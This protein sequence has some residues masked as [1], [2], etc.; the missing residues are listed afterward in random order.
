M[1]KI[2]TR[3][4]IGSVLLVSGIIL[5]QFGG[6]KHHGKGMI[7]G[8]PGFILTAAYGLTFLQVRKHYLKKREQED[9]LDQ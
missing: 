9:L 3:L 8:I 2:V 6:H 5:F 7:L 4:I 1:K